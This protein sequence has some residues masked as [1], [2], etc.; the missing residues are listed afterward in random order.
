[1]TVLARALA[2]L[3]LA[4]LVASCGD[5][6]PTAQAPPDR[7]RH[8]AATDPDGSEGPLPARSNEVNV[9][10]AG[11]ADAVAPCT[12]VSR[13]QAQAILGGS[14]EKPVEAP[15]GPTCIYRSGDGKRFV[16]L[17]VQ[18]R[19]VEQLTKELKLRDAIDVGEREAFCHDAGQPTLYMPLTKNQV[20]SVAAP[21]ILA[22][23]FA[24]RALRRL[25]R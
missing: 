3:I 4:L 20:L 13:A 23:R 10:A 24:A 21:C 7:A 25:E 5:S 11:A 19:S 8:A 15:Q 12:L 2:L 14:L 1:M 6:G 9:D 22:Q 17:A 18:S 16:T